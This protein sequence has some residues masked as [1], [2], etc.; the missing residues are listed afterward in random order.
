MSCRHLIEA[1]FILILLCSSSALALVKVDITL[2]NL[3]NSTEKSQLDANIA[4]PFAEDVLAEQTPAGIAAVKV[5][6]NVS[7]TINTSDRP[8]AD[9]QHKSKALYDIAKKNFESAAF[10]SALSFVNGSLENYGNNSNAWVLKG[11]VLDALNKS[12]ESTECYDRAIKLDN[13]NVAAWNDKGVA[14]YRMSEFDEAIA[15]YDYA[16]NLDPSN[17]VVKNNT[18]LAIRALRGKTSPLSSP[19]KNLHQ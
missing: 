8:N 10:D 11:L 13:R 7:F 16:T 18:D 12:L 3:N 17:S 14:L 2:F 5:I 4:T 1:I 6:S 9:A 15:C 19:G